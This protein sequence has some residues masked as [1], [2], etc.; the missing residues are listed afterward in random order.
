[1]S[2]GERRPPNGASAPPQHAPTPSYEHPRHALGP[3]G[4]ELSPSVNEKL[5]FTPSFTAD[6]ANETPRKQSAERLLACYR[7]IAA[8]VLSALLARRLA[9]TRCSDA[10]RRS[11]TLATRTTLRTHT[12]NV[13]QP[14]LRHTPTTVRPR[15]GRPQRIAWTRC[16]DVHNWLAF[17]RRLLTTSA[18][19]W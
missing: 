6:F 1:M 9:R 16:R 7:Y 2:G 10:C 12:A 5:L 15:R 11:R 17:Q 13:V 8:R 19:R 3:L 14:Q 18:N 4:R